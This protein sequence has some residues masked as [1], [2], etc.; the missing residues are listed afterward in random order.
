MSIVMII[1]GINIYYVIS[2]STKGSIEISE[3]LKNLNTLEATN[4]AMVNAETGIKGYIITNDE[5][6]LSPYHDAL[7]Q[8]AG[9]LNISRLYK[10]MPASTAD[11]KQLNDYVNRELDYLDDMITDVRQRNIILSEDNKVLLQSK[12]AMRNVRV[13]IS[14]L[15]NLE[16]QKMDDLN[17]LQKQRDK[18]VLIVLISGLLI[19]FALLLIYYL[20]VS[21][22]SII[23]NHLE[24]GLLAAKQTAEEAS[25]NKTQ[26]LTTVS[27]GIRSP[28]NGIVGNTSLLMQSALS[29]EQKKYAQNIQR[30]SITLLSIVND[31]LDFSK[32][33]SGNLDLENVPFV[34]RHCIEEVFSLTG[35]ADREIIM[36]HSIDEA[37]PVLVVGDMSRLWQ[38]LINILGNTLN[39]I[40]TGTVDLEARLLQSHGDE[41]MI[42]FTVTGIGDERKEGQNIIPQSQRKSSPQHSSVGLALS[43]SSRIVALMGGT[44]KVT[45]HG[46]RSITTHFTIKTRKVYEK[47]LQDA[48]I[49]RKEATEKV[50]RHMSE[51]LPLRILI[52]DD[53][54]M[55]QVLLSSILLTMG[56]SC[57]I[58]IN[59]AEALAMG[60][61]EEFD[62]IF[63]DIFMPEMDGIEATES[64]R[65]YYMNKD[66][67]II[68]AVT[69]NVLFTEKEKC[70]A[71]GMNDFLTKPFNAQHLQNMLIKWGNIKEML[72]A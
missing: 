14:K 18:S 35:S 69:A 68:I 2:Q 1:I 53:N 32:I 44:I 57:A 46:N 24:E 71:A 66:F 41:L 15:Y 50:D 8:L 33:E 31:I 29:N 9:P 62:I 40:T 16:S 6:F 47:Q 38:V 55:S 5:S 49:R 17:I 60:I 72:E 56:Y 12:E 3:S 59:G 70:F 43:I 34:L 19:C 63:M 28:L 36:T 25:N 67:P 58:A 52:A 11:I 26:F 64:L 61:E 39:T 10:A 20:M 30:S 65:K 27:H 51:K 21:K 7:M 45:N 54:E 23:R 42:G 4:T 13:T 22:N 48:V 37:L